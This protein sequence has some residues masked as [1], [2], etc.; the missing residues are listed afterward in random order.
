MIDLKLAR[1]NADIFRE[2]LARKGAAE[3]F[4]ALLAADRAWAE[5]T[6]KREDARAEQKQ[7]GKPSSQ[8]E[9]DRAR[10][11]KARLQQLDDELASAETE[12]RRL[13]EA[14]VEALSD[15]RDGAEATETDWDGFRT[16]PRKD[17]SLWIVAFDLCDKSSILVRLIG[18]ASPRGVMH[19]GTYEN[20]TH[21][22]RALTRDF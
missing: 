19:A 8:E 4:D 14:E 17:P 21:F 20:A 22:L 1:A 16:D 13:W 10:E 15:E 7:L 6:G 11:L 2:A 12:R 5:A 18:I 3:M 9:I